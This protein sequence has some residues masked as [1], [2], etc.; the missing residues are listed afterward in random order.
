MGDARQSSDGF[1]LVERASSQNGTHARSFQRRISFKAPSAEEESVGSAYLVACESAIK[2][3]LDPSD[4]EGAKECQDDCC[5]KQV[6]VRV[7]AT[8]DGAGDASK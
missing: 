2:S 3:G 6:R 1:D 5:I 7:C 8:P 4:P